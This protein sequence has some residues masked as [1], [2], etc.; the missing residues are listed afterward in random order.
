[1][2]DIGINIKIKKTPNNKR[3]AEMGLIKGTIF[4]IVKRVHGMVQL[5]FNGSDVVIT[6]ETERDIEYE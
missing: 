3:L 1:M 2:K 6:E 5:R 4:R